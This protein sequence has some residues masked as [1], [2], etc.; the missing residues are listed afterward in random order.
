MAMATVENVGKIADFAA[1]SSRKTWIVAA[2]GFLIGLGVWAVSYFHS[3]P[4]CAYT[5]MVVIPI[6]GFAKQ[7]LASGSVMLGDLSSYIVQY[8]VQAAVTAITATGAVIGLWSKI[9]GDRA[10][11]QAEKVSAQAIV[12]A[13][14]VA[15]T[16]G[17]QLSMSQIKMQSLETQL[18]A[19]K[20]D[21]FAEEARDIIGAK[22][23]QITQLNAQVQELRNL[24][25]A[26]KV[27]VREIVVV[28]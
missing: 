21:T 7:L 4:L 22:D 27:Q 13:Q 26:L 28:K 1:S 10:R 5:D 19:Y 2:A 6:S 17:Q 16:N 11:A 8:P 24:V 18:K 20:E 15:I 9:T 25:A 14:R 3:E 12:D 23:T